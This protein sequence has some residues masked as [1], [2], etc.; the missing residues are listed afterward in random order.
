MESRE[1]SWKSN[2]YSWFLVLG[3][4]TLILEDF[5]HYGMVFLFIQIFGFGTLVYCYDAVVRDNYVSPFQWRFF[6]CWVISNF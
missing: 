1:I 6:K 4:S 2:F 3:I 5:S